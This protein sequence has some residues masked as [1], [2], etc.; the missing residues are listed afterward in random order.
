VKARDLVEHSLARI[1][2]LDPALNAFAAVRA[3]E[4]RAEADALDHNKV[5]LDRFFRPITGAQLLR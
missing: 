2:V 4:A 5:S 1:A 3:A